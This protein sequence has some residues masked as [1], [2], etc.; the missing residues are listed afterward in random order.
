MSNIIKLP[1][2]GLT[3]EALWR[4]IGSILFQPAIPSIL[5]LASLRE[6][7]RIKELLSQASRDAIEL[8]VVNRA[9]KVL[10]AIG[11]LYRLNNFLSRCAL[12]NFTQ[13]RS[14]DWRKETVVV[15]GGCSGIGELMVRKFAK[16]S[17]KVVALDINPPKTPFPANAFF[18]KTD[19]T[20]SSAIR[21]TAS[22]LR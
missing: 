3:L 9:L 6:S 18:Y 16:N 10:I 19:V 12:N 13:D 17:I 2:E 14:W 4:P 22:T 15:T 8:S 1:S 21:E 5:L 20:S 7:Q 11:V